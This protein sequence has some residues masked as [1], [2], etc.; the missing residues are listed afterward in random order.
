MTRATARVFR[1]GTTP[2]RR[3]SIER[4]RR[5]PLRLASSFV[6][7]PNKED[8]SSAREVLAIAVELAGS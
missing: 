5:K 1:T 3:S 7:E 8:N 6:D 4:L 2:Q